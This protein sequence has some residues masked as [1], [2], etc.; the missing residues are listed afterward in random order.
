MLFGSDKFVTILEQKYKMDFNVLP[1]DDD[2]KHIFS[3]LEHYA[4]TD[5]YVKLLSYIDMYDYD[6]FQ[7][8]FTICLNKYTDL[9][10]EDVIN[11]ETIKDDICL[12]TMCVACMQY[13]F[14]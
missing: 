1:V 2:L 8:F 7:R 11:L 4:D 6:N 3:L 9:V 12:Q 5:V 13:Y 10:Y 14:M